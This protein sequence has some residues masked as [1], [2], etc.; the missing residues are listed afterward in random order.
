MFLFLALQFHHACL[1]VCTE[2]LRAFCFLSFWGFSLKPALLFWS[3]SSWSQKEIEA[4]DELH[5]IH[6]N[7]RHNINSNGST[8]LKLD[9]LFIYEKH[10]NNKKH[11]LLILFFSSV[12]LPDLLMQQIQNNSFVFVTHSNKLKNKVCPLQVTAIQDFNVITEVRQLIHVVTYQCINDP[13][14]E[15]CTKVHCVLFFSLKSGIGCSPFPHLWK[16]QQLST[17]AGSKKTFIL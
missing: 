11:C 12:L 13:V 14:N 2:T 4:C 5:F 16:T 1:S 10:S 3:R 8:C 7:L 15:S 6:Q 17:G 9:V